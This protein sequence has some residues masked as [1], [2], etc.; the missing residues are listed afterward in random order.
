MDLN[1]TALGQQTD[2]PDSYAPEV[3]FAINRQET[4][5]AL[6]QTMQAQLPPMFGFDVW[7]AYEVSCLNNQGKPLVGCAV[8]SVPGDSSY[9]VESKSLKLYLNSLNQSCFDSLSALGDC[10]AK[11]VSQLCGADVKVE[12]L[13]VE[14]F[15]QQRIAQLNAQPKAIC[16]DDLDV[17][18]DDYCVN[19]QLLSAGQEKTSELLCSHLLR[20]RCP[21]TG[22]P[23]WASVFIEYR[24]QQIEHASL[25]KYLVSFRLNQEFHEQCVE[26]IYSDIWVQCQPEQL[27]VTAAYLRRGG[28]D[29][30]P[31][32]SSKDVLVN[33]PFVARQ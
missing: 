5:E 18:I 4:R 1:K 29:I 13:T 10:I 27:T 2:Y 11:D 21:V 16:L 8:L 19:A 12:L 32:R 20:S 24:G 25:L 9:I 23:D 3:L 30:N 28:I 26:R 33:I 6:Q 17:K 22:Q 14:Q 7:Q 15:R 31:V